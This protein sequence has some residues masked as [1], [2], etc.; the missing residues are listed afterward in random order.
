MRK[1]QNEEQT[2]LQF[3][4][5]E[6]FRILWRKKFMVMIP[7]AFSVIVVFVGVRFLPAV[8]E[9]SV[10]LRIENAN[11]MNVE[12]E[13]IVGGGTQ[14][15]ERDG[16][17]RAKLDFDIRNGRFLDQLSMLLGF[18]KDPVVIRNAEYA[19]ANR[20]PG[21]SIDDLVARQLRS[22]L[23]GRIRVGGSGPGLFEISYQDASQEACY[24][25]AGAIGRLYVDEQQKL[26]LTGLQ[27]VSD[28]SD[29]QVIIYKERLSR[30]ERT[31]DLYRQE[32]ANTID[33]SNP[34]TELNIGVAQTLRRQFE[35][36]IE[37]VDNIIGNLERRL[38]EY[39]G[40]VPDPNEVLK[41]NEISNFQ[42]ELTARVAAEVP[43]SLREVGG[44]EAIALEARQ[45]ELA[46]IRRNI[47]SRI[48]EVVRIVYADLDQDL[49]PLLAEYHFQLV[50]L[51]EHRRELD[52]LRKFIS[53]YRRN[54]EMAPKMD[55][56]LARL[57]AE[58]LNNRSLYETFLSA[59]TSTQISEAV[60]N[61]KLAT[62]VSVVENATFPLAPV[63]PN[64]IKILALAVI[65]GLSLG[66]GGILL[67]EFSDTSFKTVE[68]VE[69]RLELRVIGTIP[70]ITELGSGWRGERKF[71]KIIVWSAALVILASV[72]IFSFYFYG[73]AAKEELITFRMTSTQKTVSGQE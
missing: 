29:E 11:V 8:Y 19:R 26:K 61:S 46:E 42:N 9:S 5:T 16:E 27:E 36:K 57:E 4:Y 13:R 63:K 14:R 21:V 35:I 39:F 1:L 48:R 10:I 32:M 72:S 68:D 37:E 17:T 7:L 66:V 54:V 62:K 52:E 3:D 33:N 49:R 34:V 71:G 43:V 18:D 30:S 23:H 67:T 70:K 55:T 53:T 24:L 20:Y 58:V 6:Y 73:K 31:L 38:E 28:F 69:K 51:N 44:T 56:E 60:Q 40:S 12:V 45:N 41:D 22:M 47:L 64:K 25:I 2:G 65:F 50:Q 59:K 15:R